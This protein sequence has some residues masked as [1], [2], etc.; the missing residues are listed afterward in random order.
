M[1]QQTKTSVHPKSPKNIPKIPPK[2]KRSPSI[3]TPRKSLKLKTRK[4]K[5][6]HPQFGQNVF[7]KFDG[8]VSML[9]HKGL[10]KS[11]RKQVIPPQKIPQEFPPP[12]TQKK[13][14]RC[15]KF[16]DILRKFEGES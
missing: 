5:K 8:T 7:L 2:Q 4:K 13:G 16:E 14:R 15:T 11:K 1:T 6:T 3:N 9:R 10:T 12:Q